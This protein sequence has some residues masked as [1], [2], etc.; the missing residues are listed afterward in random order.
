MPP[1]CE[2]EA[3]LLF[4][5]YWKKSIQ[6]RLADKDVDITFQKCKF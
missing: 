2:A 6:S 3:G 5:T 4:F 1:I